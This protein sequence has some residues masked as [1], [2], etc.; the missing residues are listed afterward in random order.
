MFA[1]AALLVVVLFGALYAVIQSPE[2]SPVE[3]GESG[4]SLSDV[5]ASLVDQSAETDASTGMS[6]LDDTDSSTGGRSIAL[7]F[8][9][10]KQLTELGV[11]T[12]FE[13][14]VAILN[15]RNGV[16]DERYLSAIAI[17]Q[18]KN[19]GS[20]QVLTQTFNDEDVEVRRGVVTGLGLLGDSESVQDLE[21][22]LNHDPSRSVRTAVI[23]ALYRV[24]TDNSREILSRTV[25]NP[26]QKLN[27]RMSAIEVLT[28]TQNQAIAN[29]MRSLLVDENSQ[30]RASAAVE[31]SRGHGDEAVSYLV[32]AALDDSLPIYV[33]GGVLS[34][35]QEIAGQDFTTA[36]PVDY[37][38]NPKIRVATNKE[39]ESWWKRIS[40]RN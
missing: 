31:L 21:T 11:D 3:S 12:S 13:N 33:W 28:L 39:I 9:A 22:F 1:F 5:G 25:I 40:A 36:R 18:L 26:T 35:L 20:R 4:Q 19:A 6:V 10:I 29:T 17:G 38:S 23:S 7:D 15:D 32:T 24:N 37:A 2:I 8:D 14:L 16:P 27:I 30:I 34:R